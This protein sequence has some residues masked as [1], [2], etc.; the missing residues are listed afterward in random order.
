MDNFNTCLQIGV[1][2]TG[3]RLFSSSL[4][5]NDLDN[6]LDHSCEPNCTVV[7][8]K[9]LAAGLV[10]RWDIPANT[11]LT[12]DYDTTEDDL[13]GDRG[14]FECNCGAASCRRHVLGRLYS[15]SGGAPWYCPKLQPAGSE[16][17]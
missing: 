12:F 14:G 4:T 11:S 8:G 10:A 17:P 6:F 15:P 5:H 9:D 7:I 3:A 16:A 1:T 13:R 2:A